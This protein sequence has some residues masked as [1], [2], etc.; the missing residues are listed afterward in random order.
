MKASRIGYLVGCD[1]AEGGSWQVGHAVGDEILDAV[2][3]FGGWLVG[4]ACRGGLIGS[5]S[6]TKGF[7][8]IISTWLWGV[9]RT[10]CLVTPG[11]SGVIVA[12]TVRFDM[13][14]LMVLR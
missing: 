12:K 2:K 1:G 14:A 11:G 7:R 3:F 9:V 5:R 8:S 10:C 13:A 4:E 6:M